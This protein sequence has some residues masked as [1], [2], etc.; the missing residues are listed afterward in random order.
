MKER[1][2]EEL[3]KRTNE[4]KRGEREMKKLK[5]DGGGF[6]EKRIRKKMDFERGSGDR[7]LE[8]LDIGNNSGTDRK[9]E[10]G[11]K[12]EIEHVIKSDEI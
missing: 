2:E 8:M 1:I 11:E 6:W 7:R 3:A 4:S 5:T 9:C 12:V 10:C